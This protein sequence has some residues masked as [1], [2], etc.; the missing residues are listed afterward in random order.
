MT[1]PPTAR[2][3]H[4]WEHQFV[5]WAETQGYALEYAANLDRPGRSGRLRAI[6]VFLRKSGF[7]GAFVWAPRAL[8]NQKR[9]FPARAVESRPELLEHYDLVLSVGHDEYWSAGMRDG[10]EGWLRATSD[11]HFPVLP[12]HFIP[13]FLSYS[14][15][16]VLK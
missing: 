13:G 15:A 7:Y 14:V 1:L 4:K 6:S 10:L 5:H 16:V 11:C 8:N 9:R 12:N 2:L 3:F